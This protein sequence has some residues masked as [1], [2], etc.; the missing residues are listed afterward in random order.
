MHAFT[1][2]VR[3]TRGA[4]PALVQAIEPFP[5]LRIYR[6][7]SELQQPS[8]RYVW[9]LGHHSGYPIAA[10][11]YPGDAGDAAWAISELADW[12]RPAEEIR[13]G[14][15]GETVRDALERT[16]GIFLTAAPA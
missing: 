15:N 12:T 8:D 10:F 1:H 16:P 2:E 13:A 3:A 11:E 7:P 4:T 5:G 9:R 14:L 6:Q